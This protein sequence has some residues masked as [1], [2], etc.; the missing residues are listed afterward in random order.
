MEAFLA[1]SVPDLISEHA[2]FEAAFLCEKSSTDSRLFAG[3]EFVR[4]LCLIRLGE[5]MMG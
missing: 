1:G 5:S 4:D 3:L 2:V